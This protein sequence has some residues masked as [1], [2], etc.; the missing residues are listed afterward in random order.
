LDV[1]ALAYY[2]QFEIV[3]KKFYEMGCW[4]KKRDSWDQVFNLLHLRLI[5]K[6]WNQ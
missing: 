6:N 5:L 3:I 4:T 2:D 1:N